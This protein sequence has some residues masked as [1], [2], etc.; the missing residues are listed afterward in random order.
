MHIRLTGAAPADSAVEREVAGFLARCD[1]NR[2]LLELAGELAAK[3]NVP[4]EQ[5]R[6]QCCNVVRTLASRRILHLARE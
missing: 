1:G 5:V 3:V 6:E 2:T 4:P